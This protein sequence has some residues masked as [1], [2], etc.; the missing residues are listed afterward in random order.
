MHVLT[1]KAFETAV[2]EEEIAASTAARLGSASDDVGA[3][4]EGR[5]RGDE[6]T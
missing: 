6:S 2:M 3:D 5:G 1:P 4:R